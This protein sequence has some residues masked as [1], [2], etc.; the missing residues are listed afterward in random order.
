MSFLAGIVLLLV[1]AEALVRGA[2]RLA[3][4]MGISP[5]VI[6]LTVVAFGTSSPE[7]AVSLR[8]GLTGAPDIALGNVVGSNIFNV[9]FVLGLSAL[10]VPLVV[11][12][13]LVR[14][15]VPVMIGASVLLYLLAL[16]GR[17]G[18]LDGLVLF[19]GIVAYTVFVIRQ[20]LKETDAVRA[21][22]EKEYGQRPRRTT[23]WLANIALVIIGL[24]MLMV[25]SHWLVGGAVAV[26]QALG[27]SELVIAL[28]IIAAGTSL[29][30][31]ATSVV[32]SIR[33]ER[34][35]AVGNVV[36]SCLFNVMAILG[37]SSLVAPE[38]IRVAP[39]ALRFDIPVMIAVSVACLPIFI[40]GYRI[41]RWEG[42][43]FLGY[44]AAYTLYLILDA[45]RHDALPVF[46]AVMGA[47]VLPLT[48]VTLAVVAIRA[49]KAHRAG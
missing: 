18:R 42:F 25:G 27:V 20:S 35:I 33:G 16:D 47:F 23:Q 6:G 24:A 44:F 41:A 13:Q 9:L 14:F 48:G 3:A 45:A 10:I 4:A 5:L 21:E 36:G 7:L 43:L 28:T 40:T 19:A 46:S 37:L 15:D 32:A 39:A 22:Y 8:A 1:G 12:Q 34:D 2:S 11:S 29:P 17:I 31:V 30:E 38:G 26:A 49:R